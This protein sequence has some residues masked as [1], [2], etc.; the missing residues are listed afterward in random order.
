[1]KYDILQK[2]AENCDIH[3]E[4]LKSEL[5]LLPRTI[6]QNEL[7]NNIKIN[8][9]IQL[10]EMVSIYKLAFIEFYKLCSICLT[11]PASSAACERTFSC[12]SHLKNY[13]T[14]SMLNERL[15]D[16]GMIQVGKKIAKTLDFEDI[17]NEFALQ[18][19]NSRIILS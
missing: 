6:H 3:L 4:S 8:N 1:M 2:F 11:M 16:L 9:L 14:N 15:C 13:L 7:K 17:I 18:H 10:T 12:P 19:K 5:N